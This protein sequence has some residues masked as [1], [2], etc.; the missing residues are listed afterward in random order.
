MLKWIIFFLFKELNIVSD[1]GKEVQRH[2]L[3][4]LKMANKVGR[5][6]RHFQLIE[7]T[8]SGE[9]IAEHMSRLAAGEQLEILGID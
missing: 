6:V 2:L 5:V 1:L 3:G 9:H 4:V 7:D 8:V